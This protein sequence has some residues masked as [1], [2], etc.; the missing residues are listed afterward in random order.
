MTLATVRRLHTWL[1]LFI[2]PSVLFFAI[3]G[4]WQ[5]FNLH[6]GHGDYTP[7]P[8]LEKLSSVHKDQVFAPG[9]HH[10]G[11]EAKP[12]GADAAP[13]PA[14][15]D[16]DDKMKP[17]TLALKVFFLVVAAGLTVST[18]L[19][20]AIGLTQSRDRRFAWAIA[21]AGAAIPLAL[22]LV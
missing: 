14:H 22:L 8:I 20:L 5:L 10:D 15:D 21:A 2:A 13:K 17:Q 6:E 16:D 11:P 7:P 9:H 19:G 3:T 12:A 18:G 1:G 4:G